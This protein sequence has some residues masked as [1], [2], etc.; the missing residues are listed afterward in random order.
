[1]SK[2]Q[3]EYDLIIL[4]GGAMGLSA[5]WQ[6]AIRGK[7]VLVLEQLTF[8]NQ[9]GSTAGDSR[10]FRLQYSQA[11]MSKLVLQAIP[12]WDQLQSYTDTQLVGKQGCLWFG[13]PNLPTEEGGVG[14]AIEV[15]DQLHIPYEPLARAEIEAR[16]PFKD[17]PSNT[18][19]FLQKYGG[20]IDVP[21]TLHTLLQVA[22]SHTAVTLRDHSP[23]TG[24]EGRANGVIV[25]CGDMRYF[26]SRLIITPGPYVNDVLR[27]FGLELKIDI[28]DMASAYYKMTEDIA[29]TPTWFVFENRPG[30]VDGQKVNEGL[31]YGFPE[32]SWSHPGYL[33]VA[34]DFPGRIISDPSQRSKEPSKKD[35]ELTD[36]WVREHMKG[37][38]P[39]AEF[40]S[41]CLIALPLDPD[42][43]MFLDQAPPG[44]PGRE[45]I[46]V[47]AGGWGAKLIPLI[48]KILVQL[49]LDGQTSYDISPFAITDADLTVTA[50][51][52]HGT[53]AKGP[54]GRLPNEMSPLL[55]LDP[56]MAPGKEL[57]IDVAIV[58]AGVSGL[59]SG[60]RLLTGHY[61][62]GGAAPFQTGDKPRV[63]VFEL[64]GRVGGRLE[65]I[66]IPGSDLVGE[67]G[68]MRYTDQMKMVYSLVPKL[69][70]L[71]KPFPMGNTDKN[72]FYL[73]RQR[74]TA[75]SWG[76]PGFHSRYF[77]D[78][79]DQG[80]SPDDL[81]TQV[82]NRVIMM[83]N[84][85]YPQNLREWND[86]TKVLRYRFSGPDHGKLLWDM[87]YWNLLENQLSFE[88]YQL[89]ADGGG[90]FSNTINWN[91][92]MALP[93]MAGDFSGP[94]T[95]YTLNGGY[96]QVPIQLGIDFVRAGGKIWAGNK[97]VTFER[98]E[99]ASGYRYALRILNRSTGE[100]W[101]V[102]TNR[103]I[104][105]MP[106][107]SLE[108][109]DQESFFFDVNRASTVQDDID[110]VIIEP[111]FKLLLGFEMPWWKILLGLESGES[112]TDLPMRQC[113]Y[114]GIDPENSHSLLLSSYNDMRTVPYW[115]VLENSGPG[116]HV[117]RFQPRGTRL[118]PA[119][120]W[121]TFPLPQ[122]PADMVDHVMDQLAQV[123]GISDLPQPYT[124]FYKDWSEDPYGGGY[125]AWKAHYKVW[126]VMPRMRKLR[127]EDDVYICGEA[128]SEQQGWVEGALNVAELML[129]EHFDM[130]WPADWLEEG[131]YLGW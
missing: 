57:E 43:L 37:L 127:P 55:Q 38:V 36:K 129:Q 24:L 14:P 104:L 99:P 77:L 103:L 88:G 114:F 96:D 8:Y 78:P 46:Y 105:A 130:T 79:Q 30:V 72:L 86:L 89:C 67:L 102:K 35:I 106:R 68:G 34:P 91:A 93:Y 120:T 119:E 26:G 44:V 128:Y 101:T 17:L 22:A 122:A 110:S 121:E 82:C 40:T 100:Y 71:P 19:G 54:G 113:Y 70:L 60:W 5:A 33:R 39:E 49:A 73:R 97:L 32:A 59:Y 11:Y 116:R 123:H 66:H 69:G 7:S 65:S 28:W 1:M 18:V 75:D 13:N 117:R 112:I 12:E 10:Q 61:R 85:K 76:K 111:S 42:K 51:I 48:G 45:N 58:G 52:G 3:K 41:T 125:H 74:F 126:E 115:S 47:Y 2:E 56:G 118:V 64:S 23:V 63:H 21:A 92:A 53:A 90:Y 62:S 4:G 107:R 98:L 131:Y 87:G 95:Y 16:Y 27:P 25:H 81:F 50:D 109:L 94:V 108:L 29:E 84:Q 9:Q 15:M 80:K 20:M 124:A 6:G 31:F 83:D